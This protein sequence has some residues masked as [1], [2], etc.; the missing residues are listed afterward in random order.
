MEARSRDVIYDYFKIGRILAKGKVCESSKPRYLAIDIVGVLCGWV[1]TIGIYNVIVPTWNAWV[2]RFRNTRRATDSHRHNI[3]ISWARI[4]RAIYLVVR[5][6]KNA[7][8]H[9]SKFISL[10][11]EFGFLINLICNVLL[12][13]P[14]HKVCLFH[15]SG[16]LEQSMH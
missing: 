7:P 6:F 14:H 15:C 5:V 12:S 2:P 10:L 1:G 16:T 8:T 3:S 13:D 11:I 9:Q 4:V